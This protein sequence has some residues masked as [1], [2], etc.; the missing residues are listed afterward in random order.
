[1]KMTAREMFHQAFAKAKNESMKANMEADRLNRHM[2]QVR[3]EHFATIQPLLGCATCK[4]A[5]AD[6]LGNEACCTNPANGGRPDTDFFRKDS[7]DAPL[8]AIREEGEPKPAEAQ[9]E[10]FARFLQEMMMRKM[11]DGSKGRTH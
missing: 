8:C 1:M 3:A 9:D 10:G 7:D 11:A 5:N 4:H 2:E 6:H